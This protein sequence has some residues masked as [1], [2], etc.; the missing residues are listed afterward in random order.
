MQNN[1]I[2]SIL[3]IIFLYFYQLLSSLV[4]L[5]PPLLGFFFIG[6]V[7]NYKKYGF[8]KDTLLIIFYLSLIEITHGMFLFSIMLYFL[9]FFYYIYDKLKYKLKNVEILIFIFIFFAYIFTLFINLFFTYVSGIESIKFDYFLI[10]YICIETLLSIIFFK[11]M[12]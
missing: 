5:L 9:I 2:K 8:D 12:I 7:V 1:S 11:D 10:Y 4:F 3:F 6:L